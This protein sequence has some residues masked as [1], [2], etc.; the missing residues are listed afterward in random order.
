MRLGASGFR[1]CTVPK[2][3]SIEDAI[4]DEDLSGGL[5]RF[6]A[7]ANVSVA[8]H[9]ASEFTNCENAIPA[10]LLTIVL[11]VSSLSLPSGFAQSPSDS[12]EYQMKVQRACE[13]A[14]C[15]MSAVSEACRE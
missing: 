14:I 10:K 6:I 1:L 3:V 11:A 15:E 4:H 12:I 13:A 8:P 9:E 5:A 2:L 7:S